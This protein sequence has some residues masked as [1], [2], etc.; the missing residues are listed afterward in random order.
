[1]VF[2]IKLICRAQIEGAIKDLD[3]DVSKSH[4]KTS[5]L[6]ETIDRV[7]KQCN[8]E[9]SCLDGKKR[10]AIRSILREKVHYEKA[11]G[12][13]TLLKRM[14]TARRN[15]PGADLESLLPELESTTNYDGYEL[16]HIW[17][18]SW[19]FRQH[20]TDK[21]NF[22]GSNYQYKDISTNE[23]ISIF[24]T[25][26]N[27]AKK[28]LY[29]SKASFQGLNK[30]LS[31]TFG[32]KI[33]EI[34][35]KVY[36]EIKQPENIPAPE[37]IQRELDSIPPAIR[38]NA[39]KALFGS[40]QTV[41]ALSKVIKKIDSMSE[42][43]IKYVNHLLTHGFNKNFL[44]KK[45]PKIEEKIRATKE[46]N[47]DRSL[48]IS[49]AREKKYHHKTA[50]ALNHLSELIS[51]MRTIAAQTGPKSL[52]IDYLKQIEGKIEN[53]LKANTELSNL[54]K[55]NFKEKFLFKDKIDVLEKK[56]NALTKDFAKKFIYEHADEFEKLTTEESLDRMHG[57]YHLDY[58]TLE[59]IQPTG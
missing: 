35:Q 55:I 3:I 48:E 51:L 4:L 9:P 30:H 56:L 36:I 25:V 54:L 50:Q 28:E 18:S 12:L 26:H 52:D 46:E 32:L 59:H 53:K 22:T 39:Y 1:M 5:N 49:K 45:Q 42:K 47:R 31:K 21:F 33:E 29:S 20:H 37:R 43:D 8:W 7:F 23:K 17:K 14:E 24:D 19:I 15:Q 13:P 16:R 40:K 10:E 57:K 27:A 58:V 44:D 34:N 11:T 6:D 2:L 41:T 38:E